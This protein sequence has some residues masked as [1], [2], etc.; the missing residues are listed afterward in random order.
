MDLY[1]ECKIKMNQTTDDF[2]VAS[3]I[4]GLENQG[5][6]TDS[7]KYHFNRVSKK[8]VIYPLFI[9]IYS[10]IETRFRTRRLSLIVNIG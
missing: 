10:P 8:A 1:K 6:K 3:L 2:N 5:L 4:E 9:Y 7:V